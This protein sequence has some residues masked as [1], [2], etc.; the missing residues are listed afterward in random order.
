MKK[1]S[2][3]ILSVFLS[4]LMVV[5]M[6]PFGGILALA[7]AKDTE[8]YFY[9]NAEGY[10]A[11]TGTDKIN[12]TN[13]IAN[14]GG[15]NYVTADRDWTSNGDRTTGFVISFWYNPGATV[16]TWGSECMF[17]MGLPSDESNNKKY[18]EVFESGTL[19]YCYNGTSYIDI[20]VAN[21]GIWN[22]KVTANKWQYYTIEIEPNGDY[23]DTLN[24]YVD[25][26]LA[27]T[28]DDSTGYNVQADGRGVC[29]F[30]ANY[31][32]K[33]RLASSLGVH[34]WTSATGSIDEVFIY[35]S[36]MKPENAM[37]L[38]ETKMKSGVYQNTKSAYQSYIATS[39][40][41]D[42]LNYG[43]KAEAEQ[44]AQTNANQLV[45]AVTSMY[46]W[47]PASFT[48]SAYHFQD[49]TTGYYNSLAYAPA[50]SATIDENTAYEYFDYDSCYYRVYMPKASVMVYTGIGA[51]P[52][53]PVMMQFRGNGDNA[54][55]VSYLA[56][57]TAATKLPLGEFWYG[58][59]DGS[60]SKPAQTSI[61]S[62]D[63]IWPTTT[64]TQINGWVVNSGWAM[65]S[66]QGNKNTHRNFKNYFEY[67]GSGNTTNYYEIYDSSNVNFTLRHRWRSGFGD[68]DTYSN[69]GIPGTVYVI[70][71]APVINRVND[72][73]TVFDDKNISDY[74]EG[75]LNS[76]L[77][78]LDGL[79]G[80]NVN[81]NN[82][83]T[84]NYSNNV[85][86]AVTACANAIK[87]AVTATYTAPVA[88]G[89]YKTLRDAMN[90]EGAIS[91]S[92]VTTVKAAYNNGT[93]PDG[94]TSS[95][96]NAFVTAYE[97]AKAKM[98]ALYSTSGS[99]NYS[100][101]LGTEAQD[102]LDAFAAL[103]HSSVVKPTITP[104]TGATVGK[105]TQLTITNNTDSYNADT[106]AQD[107]TIYY[108]VKVDGGAESEPMTVTAAKDASATVTP[109]ADVPATAS[110]VTVKAYIY[111]YE[112]AGDTNLQVSANET[113]TYNLLAAPLIDGKN[114]GAVKGKDQGDTV[115]ITGSGNIMYKINDGAYQTYSSAV[116]LFTDDSSAQ[117]ISAYSVVDGVE[118]AVSTVTFT[119]AGAFTITLDNPNAKSPLFYDAGSAVRVSVDNTKGTFSNVKY[120]II[121]DGDEDHAVVKTLA[122]DGATTS[123]SA[124][125][126]YKGISVVAY[127]DGAEEDGVEATFYNVD[128]F[129]PMIYQESF[130]GT[131]AY[132]DFL[133]SSTGVDGVLNVPEADDTIRVKQGTY[134][135]DTY[136][137]RKNVL[138]IAANSATYG[139]VLQLNENPL[140]NATNA[141]FA[142]ESGV[143]VSFWR[144]VT[145]SGDTAINTDSLDW[146]NVLSFTQTDKDHLADD[147][148]AGHYYY[149][150]LTGNGRF[151]FSEGGN[152]G[153]PY[154]DY[155]P[156]A[157]DITNHA[158]DANH[159]YWTNIVLTVDPNATTLEEGIIV[160]ING[161]PHNISSEDAACYRLKG[162][163][164]GSK[165]DKEI[166]DELLDYLTDEET[167]VLFGYGA[168][169]DQVGY[170]SNKDLYIDDVRMYTKA[171]TQA[172]INNMYTDSAADA[173]PGYKSSTSHDPTNVTVYTLGA[174][175]LTGTSYS[176]TKTA[177]DKVGQEFIDY[178]GVDPTT[179]EIT[180]YSFGTGLSIYESKDNV[181]WTVLGDSKGRTGYQNE[182]LLGGE[183]RTVLSE[184]L[185][186]AAN[187]TSSDSRT[188]AAGHLVWAPHVMYNL[189]EDKW[190]FYGST[191]SWNSSYSAVFLLSSDN[192]I[193]GYQYKEI[194]VK[195]QNGDSTN[196]IDACAYYG[197]DSEGK[198]N[199]N[200]LYMLYG[201]WG[202]IYVKTLNPNG[203]RTDTDRT[204]GDLL[205]R[206]N[207][208]GGP[209]GGEGG[210]VT[211]ENGYYYYWITAGANG[212][213]TSGGAYRQR[214]FRSE[215]P[216]SGFVDVT[217][218]LATNASSKPH[219]NGIV[220]AYDLKTNDYIYTSVGHSSL[221]K[222]YNSYGETVEINA[223]HAR[224]YSHSG[225]ATEDG[226]L[227]TRQ[228]WLIGNVAIHNPVAYTD[229]GWPTAFP[230]NYDESFTLQYRGDGSTARKSRGFN[231]FDIQG[232]YDSNTL[233]NV[234]D[235]DS[236]YAGYCSGNSCA[237]AASY[238]TEIIATDT[239]AGVIVNMK[240]NDGY[241]F[242][243]TYDDPENPTKTYITLYSGTTEYAHGVI[244]NQ[245]AEGSAIPEFS[246][247][248]NSTG[249]HVWG[250]KYETIVRDAE[251][252]EGKNQV[253]VDGVVYT[254]KASDK[255]TVYGQE[256]SDDLNY[257]T[258][259]SAGERVTTLKVNYPSE[260]AV[261]DKSAVVCVNDADFVAAGYTAGE[262]WVE[263]AAGQDLWYKDNGDGTVT[264][265]TPAQF[266]NLSEED[267]AEYYRYYVLKGTVSN[268]FH[269]FKNEKDLD[270]Q[271][272]T[273]YPE[274]GLELLIMYTNVTDSTGTLYGEY[275]FPFVMPNPAW[276]H[277]M[278]ATRN[279]Q[280]D[281]I[282]NDRQSSVGIFNRFI[283][284][285][286]EATPTYSHVLYDYNAFT[287]KE[288]ASKYGSG[289]ANVLADFD[290]KSFGR[291]DLST[292]DKIN[293]LF[294]F[295]DDPSVGINSGTYSVQEH[296]DKG[297]SAYTAV[298][299][300]VKVNY[301]ID[302]S[303]KSQY[304]EV[305]GT[306]D[307]TYVSGNKN[308]LI[309]T[310]NG[311]PFG[312]QFKMK[313]SNFLWDTTDV[314][315]IHDVTSYE[316]NTTGLDITYQTHEA[317]TDLRYD[318]D[319]KDDAKNPQNLKSNR[320][321]F[322]TASVTWPTNI[323][324]K[325]WYEP[326]MMFYTDLRTYNDQHFD[327]SYR[328]KYLELF[329]LGDTTYTFT[330]MGGA[331]K[332]L[333]GSNGATGPT[334][335]DY[336]SG[337][338]TSKRAF[339]SY[340]NGK[341]DTHAWKGTATFSGKNAVK[342]NEYQ[343]VY[344]GW[345]YMTEVDD[346]VLQYHYTDS[347][348]TAR[349]NA[350]SGTY[351][352]GNG[353]THYYYG[354][355]N[356]SAEAYA[357]YILEF[358]AYHKLGGLVKGGCFIPHE[359]YNYYNIGVET[360]D[361][362]AVREFVDTFANK[363]FTVN[364][365][366][367][368]SEFTKDQIRG[369]ATQ[370]GD[371]Q[372]IRVTSG[373]KAADYTVASFN[374][375]L[376]ALGEAYWFVNNPRNTT[377]QS[378][379]DGKTYEYSVG[380][381]NFYG[382][383][384]AAIYQADAAEHNIF[385]ETTATA[386]SYE[387][388]DGGDNKPH[389]DEVQADI[390]AD[391]IIA[392]KNLYAVSNYTAAED[393][394]NSIEISDGV[395]G[396]GET[397]TDGV[398]TFYTDKTKTD[399]D[400]RITK[401]NFTDDSWDQFVALVRNAG[402]FFD[403]YT[404]GNIG[405]EGYDRVDTDISS[406]RYVTMTGE[407]Y[408][409]LLDIIK[410]AQS[411]LMEQLDTQSL[412]DTY[413]D[414]TG[415]DPTYGGD[416]LTD[417]IYNDQSVQV[418]TFD[419]WY[420]MNTEANK[421][422]EL[423][424]AAA[425]TDDDLTQD[426]PNKTAY[427]VEDGTTVYF[428][429]GR[430]KVTDVKAYE[431]D[432]YT[433]Y[434]QSFSTDEFT[435]DGEGSSTK[436]DEA[437][438]CSEMQDTVYDESA[439][440]AATTLEDCDTAD[441]YAAYDAAYSA[442][443]SV[444]FD[445]YLETAK[446]GSDGAEALVNAELAKKTSEYNPEAET[447]AETVYVTLTSDQVAAYNERMGAEILET[448][449][450]Y[451]NTLHT[452]TDPITAAL[453]TVF[454]T[455]EGDKENYVKKFNITYTVKNGDTVV[456]EDSDSKFY[457]E[458]TKDFA[459][460]E[461][462]QGQSKISITYT[463]LDGN[464]LGSVKE[465]TQNGT[466]FSRIAK[467]NMDITLAITQNNGGEG[468]YT[469]KICN[470]Y[471]TVTD[472]F[473]AA[474][475]DVK[476][477]AQ[478]IETKTIT[479]GSKS[480]TAPLV[481]YYTFSAWQKSTDDE[482]KVV[483]FTPQYNAGVTVNFTV[484]Q[485]GVASGAA[486]KET[487]STTY[488]TAFDTEVTLDASEV[489]DFWAWAT[490]SGDNLYQIA[491]YSPSYKF[492]AVYGNNK[493]DEING[494]QFVA[495]RK[496]DGRYYEPDGKTEL[497][498]D[499]VDTVFNI[500]YDAEAV[501]KSK[502][503]K[504]LPFVSLINAELA[505]G[506]KK[507]T[508]YFRITQGSSVTPSEFGTLATS[509]S[510]N[511]AYMVEGSASKFRT[512]TILSSGQYVFTINRP[513]S[514]FTAVTFRGYMAYLFPYDFTHT[515]NT[516]VSDVEADLNVT[517]YSGNIAIAQ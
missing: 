432:D 100:A 166:I 220:S 256:I 396:E 38:F 120:K 211:Y 431:F 127:V 24:F 270:G 384:H 440:L 151:S 43:G 14:N 398:I 103:A 242:K 349:A 134:G 494:E 517:E 70:N 126:N 510:A 221:Y 458:A 389:T 251:N 395:D 369:T 182:E 133:G 32:G 116:S 245:G 209:G 492:Y 74:K 145:P 20:D 233:L 516:S 152:A 30:F 310:K 305:A 341:N 479:I 90:Y 210:Y 383:E 467:S 65:D 246:Y 366:T 130:N 493:S 189:N 429:N 265:K 403:Y 470:V 468:A 118:S 315:A 82:T 287:I 204:L 101:A 377:Y 339:D 469:V 18:F 433:Y 359:T 235:D 481:P 228:I 490:V 289:V 286:G 200:A 482:E 435:E 356:V 362:G 260:I 394:Y 208:N 474:E 50:P 91:D 239:D 29:D 207:G 162:N 465:K 168:W 453:L 107:G 110:T 230:L 311:V 266:K 473:T 442:V 135:L 112:N 477:I 249:Q 161:E 282:G 174:D 318:D 234:G 63:K 410:H 505:E 83:N 441:A 512:S 261:N 71:Y 227:T 472:I 255:Y 424:T 58:Y 330:D 459:V 106:K 254:H 54:R 460:P 324:H 480:F 417:G 296:Q 97:A 173:Q 197:R 199:P 352:D 272:I 23:Y 42:A 88:D 59:N 269:Y 68:D 80:D 95:T 515:S 79:T 449:K 301:Y 1:M 347:E 183:Y 250:Y 262:Y 178:Y 39:T 368:V 190:M 509:K 237:Y 290:E 21:G 36:K 304:Q 334:I 137:Q 157:C 160:Y 268:Y 19:R 491:S 231:A 390:I 376:D 194:V 164:F 114:S 374:E 259:T 143:T 313:A 25:G 170:R 81:P 252:Y 87:S 367:A 167:N 447:R 373:L 485:G 291:T 17:A 139:N 439:T 466:T 180:Y 185:A 222:A 158:T 365:G 402:A 416:K 332:Y 357:N 188:G 497:K 144:Y 361:K 193:S 198:I 514:A 267:K 350:K 413:D 62:A 360:C 307:N 150:V 109:F 240:S 284:S 61:G 434:A 455:V 461:E 358:G 153:G 306:S 186:W 122:T 66:N 281:W 495:I 117:T 86:S 426:G 316:R 276:A 500:N 488:S 146:L 345:Y 280:S 422:N 425:N 475:A 129:D 427:E 171:L 418:K 47:Q 501:L 264:T 462:A 184:A 203:T 89:Q 408:N 457:G 140:A 138:K 476:D 471:G 275:E 340:S 454:N 225:I 128:K 484:A 303:D 506:K 218:S 507:A 229:N 363:E 2:K 346:G 55:A 335:H 343:D 278:A 274:K 327:Y 298:P 131:T 438:N 258:D 51:T 386:G 336:W 420:N 451:K 483:V 257:L 353:D 121:P 463:D 322:R 446:D 285:Y 436:Y 9:D 141:A 337:A 428:T 314:A 238:D 375:Y 113:V 104:A 364:N 124:F 247:V 10:S 400:Y 415:A 388:R 156:N 445:K 224:E 241:S 300:V 409:N 169:A 302:Y 181:N 348:A 399:V 72:L 355:L 212:W 219:G 196:A 217:G 382:E 283:D 34:N 411:G 213:G 53:V 159:G 76:F 391:V 99:A 421:A 329:A 486:L 52:K 192:P 392:Y 513:S 344:D 381:D 499:K 430:Y 85:E 142:K 437:E 125:M 147:S 370:Q 294:D 93:N 393:F 13:Y 37:D 26:T 215:N 78:V 56:N 487:G 57:A 177:G 12:G 149:A 45:N 385:D 8:A 195:T 155:F 404:N 297:P 69:L 401:D 187:D 7:S 295:Y 6:L 41:L 452:G 450:D 317:Y 502:L 44:Y 414:K 263:Y 342:Q 179:C 456:A 28:L 108:T 326:E 35:P 202:D 271:R 46:G 328:K 206:A 22:N 323:N 244:A 504:K 443:E 405:E 92:S 165:T 172:E 321:G 40:Q 148:D 423:L 214:V 77:T 412:S 379:V 243:L 226:Q 119:R 60:G 319:A 94:Y 320:N 407:A 132:Y 387:A 16:G 31:S 136:D 253:E 299:D 419:S 444:N 448:G 503:D 496:I 508:G 216:T 308:G 288:D 176:G 4:L 273:G 397:I 372:D 406:W 84:Y 378:S 191:S 333:D 351:T 11:S 293:T 67:T 5:T 277:T 3:R 331:D 325:Y 27:Y 232:V 201:S 223:A 354:R 236:N 64:T 380:Y 498:A 98:A 49:L 338:N 489:E 105:N 73:S 511:K 102:L 75:G 154:Y 15:T 292:V 48:A 309:K 96:Y 163:G 464:A 115:A 478:K 205:A 279:A 111:A 123:T 371:I 175:S 248:I 312:Y 33:V